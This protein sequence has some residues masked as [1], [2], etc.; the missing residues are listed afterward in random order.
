MGPGN[1]KAAIT[2]GGRGDIIGKPVGGP[3][4]QTPISPTTGN[5]P[6]G[7]RMPFHKMSKGRSARG[8]R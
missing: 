7:K 4:P 6:T 2:G 1:R 5:A 3:S 8:R